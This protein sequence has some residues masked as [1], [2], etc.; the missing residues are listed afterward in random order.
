MHFHFCLGNAFKTI[1]LLKG[2][3]RLR[4]FFH[5]HV[6]ADESI[7][8]VLPFKLRLQPRDGLHELAEYQYLPITAAMRGH[9]EYTQVLLTGSSFTI[10][11]EFTN[12]SENM[13]QLRERLP[14]VQT[15]ARGFSSL[16]FSKSA[17]KALSLEF[18]WTPLV[19]L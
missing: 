19:R 18:I 9:K 5:R 16:T 10:H 2:L 8:N 6:A 7:V 1:D 4:P 17:S 3:N 11:S 14:F 13:I 15:L 12:Q